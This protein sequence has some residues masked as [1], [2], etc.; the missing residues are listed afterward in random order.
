[1]EKEQNEKIQLNNEFIQLK[2]QLQA[3]KENPT[4]TMRKLGT[5]NKII[6]AFAKGAY[7]YEP[8]KSNGAMKGMLDALA[9]A[10]VPFVENT[11]RRHLKEAFDLLPRDSDSD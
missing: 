11:L 3:I 6:G 5:K 10:G 7:K 1:M 2:D 8:G 4:A 9:L